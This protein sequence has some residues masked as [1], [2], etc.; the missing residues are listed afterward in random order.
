MT[1]LRPTRD[2]WIRTILRPFVSPGPRARTRG[3]STSRLVVAALE[4]R[5]LLSLSA[6]PP[7]WVS[8]GPEPGVL[9]GNETIPAAPGSPSNPVAGNV[10]AVAIDPTDP[11]HMLAGSSDGG[12]WT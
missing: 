7:T 2:S 12:I 4:A 9:K 5:W 1:I 11:Q 10:I 6:T 3:G 8:E